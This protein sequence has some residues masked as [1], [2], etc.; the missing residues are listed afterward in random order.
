MFTFSIRAM[1]VRLQRVYFILFFVVYVTWIIKLWITQGDFPLVWFGV[2]TG[3]FGSGAAFL[4]YYTYTVLV[5]EPD[6]LD[7]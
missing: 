3:I 4:V 1:L 2:L 6:E 7:V 5:D